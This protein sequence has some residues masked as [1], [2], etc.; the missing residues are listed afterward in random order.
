VGDLASVG[1]VT[2]LKERN[3]M[4]KNIDKLITEIL[5]AKRGPAKKL[6]S[7]LDTALAGIPD[8]LKPN[9]KALA[10][11]EGELLAAVDWLDNMSLQAS[12][13]D[14]ARYQTIA[15]HW[16]A[17]IAKIRKTIKQINENS[18]NLQTQYANDLRRLT[19]EADAERRTAMADLRDYYFDLEK[20]ATA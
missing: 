18:R 14:I 13:D 4:N 1:R 16:P 3:E 17:R 15:D 2:L 20:L 5:A 12:P 11:A 7:N 8:L 19:S 10:V 9:E 6:K